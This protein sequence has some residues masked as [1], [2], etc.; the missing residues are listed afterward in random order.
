[1]L[2]NKGP[3]GAKRGESCPAG[4]AAVGLPVVQLQWAQPLSLPCANLKS[5]DNSCQDNQTERVCGD[6]CDRSFRVGHC[7]GH[8]QCLECSSRTIKI[9]DGKGTVVLPDETKDLSP[10]LHS[11]NSTKH[12]CVYTQWRFDGKSMETL[13]SLFLRANVVEM[14]EIGG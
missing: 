13:R 5:P 9:D 8:D 11:T 12:S 3:A 14:G 7:L 4:L 6:S 10:P 2:A 1:M